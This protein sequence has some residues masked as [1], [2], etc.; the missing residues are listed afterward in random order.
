MSLSEEDSFKDLLLKQQEIIDQQDLQ[1]RLKNQEIFTLYQQI[2]D[3]QN[4]LVDTQE[5]VLQIATQVD[6]IKESSIEKQE[7]Y[8]KEFLSFPK[9]QKGN[10]KFFSII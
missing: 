9:R 4:R 10:K 8:R 5:M 1:I 6:D 7:K 3:C 2:Q